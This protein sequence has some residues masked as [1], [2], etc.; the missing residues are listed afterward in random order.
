MPTFQPGGRF[1]GG[2]SC[3]L[4]W[5]RGTITAA[6]RSV[7]VTGGHGA[8]GYPPIIWLWALE[9]SACWGGIYNG[10][11]FFTELD[12]TGKSHYSLVSVY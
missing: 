5:Q 7:A 3:R 8:R 4:S 12:S 2:I 10:S 1:V 11:P 6:Q 9:L